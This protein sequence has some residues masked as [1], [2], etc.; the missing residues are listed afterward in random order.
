MTVLTFTVIQSDVVGLL[1]DGSLRR[2][3]RSDTGWQEI[4]RTTSTAGR[5][6]FRLR[7]NSLVHSNGAFATIQLGYNDA[8]AAGKDSIYFGVGQ[9]LQQLVSAHKCHFNPCRMWQAEKLP[10]YIRLG[11]R[12]T[13]ARVLSL[14]SINLIHRRCYSARFRAVYM[15]WTFE[16]VPLLSGLLKFRKHPLGRQRLYAS[17][18]PLIRNTATSS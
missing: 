8:I 4:C 7:R 15:S 11:S 1:D 2:W 3:R 14:R 17:G 12:L 10:S 13:L 9:I 5:E 18:N 6:S 16:I